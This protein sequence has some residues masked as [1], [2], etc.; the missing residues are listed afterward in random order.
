MECIDFI[1]IMNI[2]KLLYEMKFIL[3]RK[4]GMT[5]V[6]DEDGR[7][8]AVTKIGALPCDISQ[9]KNKDKDSYNAVQ[10]KSFKTAD[11]KRVAKITEFKETNTKK[12]KTGEKVDLS[13]FKKNDAV[14]VEGTSKGKGFAGTIKRHGFHMGPVSHGSKNVRKP[15]SIGGGY[16]ERVVKGKKMAGRMGGNNVTVK[17]LRVM[18][19]DDQFILI[20]GA[21]PG[22]N[23]SIVKVYGTGEKVEE[24]VDHTAEEERIAREKMM[25]A[26]KAEKAEKQKEAGSEEKQAAGDDVSQQ[27]GGV[28]PQEGMK[29]EGEATG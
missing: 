2:K 8:F 16:P 20:S 27:A 24:I 4:I 23:G 7:H 18:D 25:E 22:P 26:E 19:V 10:V 15:G 9:I 11:K 21:V 29:E 5:R 12:Y 13:Q 6:F 1:V 3:G 14:T 17:N 28:K